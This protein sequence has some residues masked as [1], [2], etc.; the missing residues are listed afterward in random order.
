VVSTTNELIDSTTP[1]S[2]FRWDASAQQWIFNLS[3]KSLTANKTYGYRIAL[4]DGT[5]ID[6]QFGLK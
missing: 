6:F 3:T 4:K 2:A 1:D 5:N